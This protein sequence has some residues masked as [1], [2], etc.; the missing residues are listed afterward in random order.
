MKA[1][2]RLVP[3]ISLKADAVNGAAYSNVS[4]YEKILGATAYANR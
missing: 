4:H 2:V 1:E 3:N